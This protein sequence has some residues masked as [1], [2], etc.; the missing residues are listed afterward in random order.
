M[1]H[2]RFPIR[3]LPVSLQDFA[4]DMESIVDHVF[5]SND[6]KGDKCNSTQP[7]NVI[8]PAI[9][10]YE[11]EQQF[12]LY[13][14][15]PGVKPEEVKLEIHEERLMVSGVRPAVVDSEGVSS[16]RVERLSGPFSRSIQLPPQLDTE[17]IEAHFEN[18][19]L[20]VVM[21]KQAK[22]MPRKIEIKSIA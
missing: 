6:S 17:K 20:H 3:Q 4:T 12:D 22:T 11:T 15:L 13:I 21:P 18:G 5:H 10:I 16:H 9:D 8:R 7:S 14:D 19:T 1:V 2:F